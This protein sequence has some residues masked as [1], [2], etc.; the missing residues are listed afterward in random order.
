ML[1]LICTRLEPQIS[2]VM[3]NLFR[4]F[5]ASHLWSDQLMLLLEYCYDIQYT[6]YEHMPYPKYNNNFENTIISGVECQM[7]SVVH[8]CTGKGKSKERRYLENT[9]KQHRQEVQYLMCFCF[10]CGKHWMHNDGQRREK[11]AGKS[12]FNQKPCF[13]LNGVYTAS[14]QITARNSFV[15][16][17]KFSNKSQ[18]AISDS[19]L[20]KTCLLKDEG[21]FYRKPS[22]G[23]DNFCSELT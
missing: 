2:S 6:G 8:R 21:L 19:F 3:I 1:L 4:L 16:K 14:T 15:S 10:G 13:Y 5:P 12:Q 22:I 17:K 20:E 18:F 9:M 23:R 7:H 11:T